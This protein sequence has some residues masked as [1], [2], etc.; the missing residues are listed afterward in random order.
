ENAAREPEIGDV[1]HCLIKMG[2]LIEGIDSSTLRIQGRDRLEGATHT[3]LPDR[4][5]AGTF[6]MAVA[7]TGGDVVLEG[8]RR[9]LLD[10][11]LDTLASTGTE[12]TDVPGGL[13]IKRNGHAIEPISV[14]TQPFP[15]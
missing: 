14:E 8:A 11:A 3:V 2:A 1:A 5:E 13:R 7:A 4:I 6:A 10:T 9:D 12:V 15:G